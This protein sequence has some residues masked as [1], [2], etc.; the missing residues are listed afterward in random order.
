MALTLAQ[1]AQQLQLPLGILQRLAHFFELP[2]SYYHPQPGQPRLRLFQVAEAEALAQI[3]TQLAQGMPLAELKTYWQTVW[4]EQPASSRANSL[5]AAALSEGGSVPSALK[6]YDGSDPMQPAL[7]ESTFA[8]YQADTGL[9]QEPPLKGLARRLTED[10]AARM[11]K[12]YPT[13]ETA[14]LAPKRN[15]WMSRP[16][17][18][19]GVSLA[20]SATGGEIASSHAGSA[21]PASI[22]T[23]WMSDD[24]REQAWQLQQQLIQKPARTFLL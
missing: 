24:L 22:E 23:E 15:P 14:P 7:A 13:P 8:H 19:S 6:T 17:G 2:R 21:P 4:T 10:H 20:S 11:A 18:V 1:L 5:H 16:S 9:G 12:H 3:R